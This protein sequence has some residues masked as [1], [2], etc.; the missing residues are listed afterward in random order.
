MNYSKKLINYSFPDDVAL[1]FTSDSHFN[2]LNIIKFCNR[3]FK[4]VEEMNE[5]L[6]ENWNKVVPKDG[7]VF[8]LGD[9]AFGGN[10]NDIINRLNGKIHLIIGNHDNK[11]MKQSYMD[12]F[13]SVEYQMLLKIGERYV[14]LNHYPFLCYGGTYRNDAVWQ[15]Y[16]H[17]HSYPGNTGK[18]KDR[19]IHT[20]PF[21]YDVGVD[22]N[23]YFPISWK[24]VK[25][26]IEDNVRKA[27]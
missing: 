26:K 27:I 16:G 1:F 7:I 12:K 24:E 13:E 4:D 22:N 23:N 25:E 21:Q 10:W 19:L 8:H 20:F 15:L 2:H 6:I 9:F 5:K 18:D 11:S 14:Y 17:V 3:P